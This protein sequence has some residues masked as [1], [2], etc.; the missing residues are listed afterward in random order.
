MGDPSQ[1]LFQSLCSA[2]WVINDFGN[3]ASQQTQQV[4]KE[5]QW[6]LARQVNG[7]LWFC[8]TLV[9][10]GTYCLWLNGLPDP[11]IC[12]ITAL[13]TK[14]SAK[15]ARAWGPHCAVSQDA[16]TVVV[17][18]GAVHAEQ[19]QHRAENDHIFYT[20]QQNIATDLEQLAKQTRPVMSWSH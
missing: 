7:M 15:L 12:R 13:Q 19:E 4:L 17:L 9:P 8:V 1:C 18:L 14:K 20:I 6:Y 11:L 5:L 3:N 16:I 10:H 2:L